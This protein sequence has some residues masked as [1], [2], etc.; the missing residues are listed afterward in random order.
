VSYRENAIAAAREAGAEIARRFRQPLDVRHKAP[1]DLVTEA[2]LAAE[3]VILAMI[4]SR[5]PEHGIVTEESAG[6]ASPSPYRWIIDPLDG[7][8]NFAAGIPFFAVCLA[9]CYEDRP[10]LGVVY[11]PIGDELF[12]AERGGGAY[13]NGA[14]IGVSAT[15]D[16]DTALVA[17]ARSYHPS[18]AIAALGSRIYE[19]LLPRVRALRQFGDTALSFAYVAC[20][21]LDG[22]VTPYTPPGLEHPAGCLLVEE[23]G[24]VATDLTGAP[25][26]LDSTSIVGGVPAVQQALLADL[27]LGPETR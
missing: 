23:A 19:R 10:V 20:G 16:L 21:R 12:W 9:L 26:R 4:R 25:W 14:P 8:S 6:R 27:D 1:K 22:L 3:R 17:Y 2:D 11:D 15:T 7:T 24:G 5:Y 18:P 13:R